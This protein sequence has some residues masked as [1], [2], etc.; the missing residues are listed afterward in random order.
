M[1][2]E[3]KV[4]EF[5][6]LVKEE[7]KPVVLKFTADWCPGCQQVAPVVE[8]IAEELRD[9]VFYDVNVD[10]NLE[11]AQQQ[12]GVMSIPTLILFKNGEEIDRITAPEPSNDTIRAFA[13][14]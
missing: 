9:V 4:S 14:Q 2:K 5:D 6:T 8:A 12:Y 3:L 10:N 13:T 11:F 7:T 1:L